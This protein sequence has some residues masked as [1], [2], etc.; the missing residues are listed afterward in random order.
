MQNAFYFVVI[1]AVRRWLFALSGP[2]LVGKH[3]WT[4]ISLCVGKIIS[5]VRLLFS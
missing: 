4:F 3:G 2:V 5:Y 1:F